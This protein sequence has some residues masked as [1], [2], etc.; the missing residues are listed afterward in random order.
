MRLGTVSRSVVY[1]PR[2]HTESRT[3]PSLPEHTESGR[4]PL[5][6][7]DPSVCLALGGLAGPAERG[8]SPGGIRSGQLPQE[9]VQ[10]DLV[11]QSSQRSGAS[12][13]DRHVS[14]I[15]CMPAR[16]GGRSRGSPCD[17]CRNSDG[18]SM[19]QELVGIL[20]LSLWDSKPV[21]RGPNHPIPRPHPARSP[22]IIRRGSLGGWNRD[23]PHGSSRCTIFSL[24]R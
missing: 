4:S 17:R 8:V 5:D 6:F 2:S 10:S 23:S 18:G 12:H 21:K 7:G 11:A 22:V 24:D 19:R 1:C 14:W 13:L 15:S 9:A 20:S 16:L 3:P